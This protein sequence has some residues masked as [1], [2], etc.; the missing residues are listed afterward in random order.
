MKKLI[1]T[2]LSV[3]GACVAGDLVGADMD[4]NLSGFYAGIGVSFNHSEFRTEDTT[5]NVLVHKTKMNALG[6]S[7]A[8]GYNHGFGSFFAGLEATL[9]VCKNKKRD[10]TW[11]ADGDTFNG[12]CKIS[13][14]VPTVA[15]RVG[16]FVPMMDAVV[17]ARAGVAYQKCE[18]DPVVDGAAFPNAKLSKIMPVVGLGVE[19]KINCLT[20]RLEGDYRF[21][22]NKKFNDANGNVDFKNKNKGGY[23]VRLMALY[24]F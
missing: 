17:Y 15:L 9:D 22:T 6:G 10:F 8:L 4:V 16:G 21:R 18:C 19:K 24:N 7:V 11:T 13:G 14:V 20:A 1:L 2:C 3:A 12:K 5:D 23:T